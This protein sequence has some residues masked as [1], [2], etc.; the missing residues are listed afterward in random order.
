MIPWAEYLKNPTRLAEYTYIA[1]ICEYPPP[2]PPPP[3]KSQWHCRIY[4]GRKNN[5][6]QFTV[7]I[8]GSDAVTQIIAFAKWG[9]NFTLGREPQKPY[10]SGGKYLYS[11]YMGIPPSRDI[12]VTL[13]H[14]KFFG[15][16]NNY[17]DSQST[18]CCHPWIR[19]SGPNQ[20]HLLRYNE[21][22]NTCIFV[23]CIVNTLVLWPS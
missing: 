5:Y 8:R 2:P 1:H 9:K 18:Y 11:T 4:F 13:P 6:S 22:V 23:F 14:F 12:N 15:R 16:Q 20:F 7:A 17:S 3:G 21:N 10:L 19:C